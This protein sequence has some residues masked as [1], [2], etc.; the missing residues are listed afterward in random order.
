MFERKVYKKHARE[1]LKNRWKAPLQIS[2]ATTSF[3]VILYIVLLSSTPT[4]ME[5]MTTQN[6][7]YLYGIVAPYIVMGLIA[8][9]IF[10]TIHITIA[11]FYLSFIKNNNDSTFRTFLEGFHLWGK[12]VRSYF[13]MTLWVF[14]WQ[15]A[16]ITPITLVSFFLVHI[17][18]MEFL[19]VVL[20]FLFYAPAIVKIIAYSQM[21]FVIADNPNVSVRRA[22]EISIEMTWSYKI[23][24]F[25]MVLSFFSWMILAALPAII[26]LLLSLPFILFL[27]LFVISY[28]LYLRLASYTYT[29]FTYAYQYLKQDA[30]TCKIFTA[31]DFGQEEV[32][33]AIDESKV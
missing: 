29:S 33:V 3:F 22:M 23:E 26:A 15:L 11:Y 9:F 10:G 28:I 27:F 7:Q 8:S 6:W 19:F 20:P 17:T 12:G 16:F 21:F 31:A 30:I 4:Q 14:L 24:L 18:K 5:I 2:F 25:I 13:W 1:Q 32:V